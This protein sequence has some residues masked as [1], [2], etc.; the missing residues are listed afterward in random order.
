MRIGGELVYLERPETVVARQSKPCNERRLR[1]NE[2][3]C[4]CRLRYSF[5]QKLEKA[6]SYFAQTN[7][8]GFLRVASDFTSL[9]C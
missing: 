5:F 9:V 6:V 3:Y 8:Y 2:G 4:S 1:Q 7:Y